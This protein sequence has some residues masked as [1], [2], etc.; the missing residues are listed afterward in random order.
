MAIVKIPGQLAPNGSFPV[1]DSN[2]IKGGF[3]IVD[4][5]EERDSIGTLN[6]KIGLLCYVVEKNMY[7]RLRN[8]ITND[9]W[10]DLDLDNNGIIINNKGQ[11][12]KKDVILD[13]DHSHDNIHC[14]VL[15]DED[16]NKYHI[17]TNTDLV[18]TSNNKT[19]TELLNY[20]VE[21]IEDTNDMPI[22]SI[23]LNNNFLIIKEGETFKFKPQVLP[24]DN[25]EK[26]IWTSQ[27]K[28]IATISQDGILNAIK[29][30]AT[31]IK[32]YSNKT[33]ITDTCS[34]IVSKEDLS[35]K[36]IT[37]GL[38]CDLNL[39]GNKTDKLW[40]DSTDNY[41][42]AELINVKEDDWNHEYLHLNNDGYIKLP[43]SLLN[44][45]MTTIEILADL[46]FDKD[47]KKVVKLFCKKN[48]FNDMNYQVNSEFIS[49]GSNGVIK[50]YENLNCLYGLNLY[51]FVINKISKEILIY[52]N[53]RLFDVIKLEGNENFGI[54]DS[55]PLLIASNGKDQS[56]SEM[57]IS[58]IRIFERT[59]SAEEVLNEAEYLTGY[60]DGIETFINKYCCSNGRWSKTSPCFSIQDDFYKK[61]YKYT[62][63]DP[64][65]RYKITLINSNYSGSVNASGYGKEK[66]DYTDLSYLIYFN[67]GVSY[68]SI[69]NGIFFINF[70]FS[71]NKDKNRNIY[72]I[73]EEIKQ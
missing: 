20:I 19:L 2:D 66:N 30:G 48:N 18:M 29:P 58:R 63:I 25:T 49:F 10:D 26:L 46:M 73:L 59:L 70:S 41:N 56:S 14:T 72:Y 9:N 36:E 62:R 27:D 37:E 31:F 8:G 22:E 3:Y 44:S 65:K 24:E 64:G 39:K 52:V 43:V 45:E 21:K 71:T 32:V 53:G 50:E 12:V 11:E 15:K 40:E 38:I 54:S 47:N 1:I 34:I 55:S 23:N 51:T 33:R 60:Y 28:S 4:T 13:I 57:K 67:N 69:P 42:N 17:E 35:E 16:D 6:R 61:S 68:F 5:I 7:Y